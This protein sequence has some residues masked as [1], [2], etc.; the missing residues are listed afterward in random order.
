MFISIKSDSKKFKKTLKSFERKH[1]PKA[2]A[3]AINKVLP[4]LKKG[5]QI[6]MKKDLD[7]PTPFTTSDRAFYTFKANDD[8]IVKKGTVGIKRIQEGYLKR[9]VFGGKYIPAK[10]FVPVPTDDADLN[11]YGNLVGSRKTRLKRKGYFAKKIGN[12]DGVWQRRGDQLVLIAQFAK[13]INYVKRPFKFFEAGQRITKKHFPKR[14]RIELQKAI[15]RSL[16]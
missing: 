12:V 9:Q 7:R 14:L 16:R 1:F 6:Q 4:L 15:K 5:A 2:Q 10:G 3:N 8:Q 11:K 13:S